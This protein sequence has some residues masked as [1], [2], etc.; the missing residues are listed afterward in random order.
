MDT[1]PQPTTNKNATVDTSPHTTKNG[2][3]HDLCCLTVTFTGGNPFINYNGFDVEWSNIDNKLY[4]IKF[5]SCKN[6]VPN[7]RSTREEE[8]GLVG[9]VGSLFAGFCF[10]QYVG[11]KLNLENTN[12]SFANKFRWPF[13]LNL[14]K[15]LEKKNNEHKH[16]VC[17]NNSIVKS[18][19]K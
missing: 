8:D 1:P 13:F 7:H 16:G 19:W 3:G 14:D 2:S 5:A 15:C 12:I 18:N 4:W 9:S 10:K 11:E 6:T 17:L